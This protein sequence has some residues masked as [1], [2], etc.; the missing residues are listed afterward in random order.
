MPVPNIVTNLNLEPYYDTTQQELDKGYV[1]YLSIS[2]RVLQNRELNVS[3]GLIY[4]NVRK[5]TDL[6]VEDGSI[7]S[8]CNFV[9]NIINETCTLYSGEMY[10]NGVLVKIPEREWVYEE[11]PTEL[12]YVYVKITQEIVTENEDPSLFD[13]AENIENH[14]N[15]GGHRLKYNAIPEIMNETDFNAEALENKNFIPIIKLKNRNSYGPLK[16][17]PVFGKIYDYLAQRTYDSSGDFLA[18][19]LKV[20][21]ERNKDNSNLKFNVRVTKGRA[22]IRGY[23][24]SY[25]KDVYI[26]QDIAIDTRRSGGD[27][28]YAPEGET[29]HS[30]IN[31]Y[32]LNKLYIKSIEQI[33][34]TVETD[35]HADGWTMVYNSSTGIDSIP[36]QFNPITSIDL[37]Y[38]WSG[39]T[40]VPYIYNTDYA[41]DSGNNNIIWLSGGSHPAGTY[42]VDL[43][44]SKNLS[45]GVDYYITKDSNGTMVNFSTSGLKPKDGSVFFISYTWYLFRID[46]VYLTEDGYIN[47]KK[48]IPD[49]IENVLEPSIPLGTL[50][51][52][53]INVQP[54]IPPE[55]FGVKSF[56]IYR[57]PVTQ[58]QDMKRKIQDIEYNFAMSELENLAQNKHLEQ[59]DLT[60]LKNIF[61]DAVTDYKKADLNNPNYDATIDLFKSEIR[62]PMIIDQV[63][64][65]KVT[66]KN[67]ENENVLSK[68]F[69]LPRNSNVVTDFQPYATHEMDIAPFYYKGLSPTII[70]DPKKLVYIKDN[71]I[72]R[73]IWLDNRVVF[74]SS[75][76]KLWNTVETSENRLSGFAN[77]GLSVGLQES[78]GMGLWNSSN[79]SSRLIDTR[80]TV[81]TSTT[82]S[83]SSTIIGEEVVSTKKEEIDLVPQPFIKAGSVIKVT[84]Q[85]FP[86]NAE[87]GLL[88]D[89]QKLLSPEYVNLRYNSSILPPS[90]SNVLTDA[91]FDNEPVIRRDWVWEW[92]YNSSLSSFIITHPLYNNKG[93]SYRYNR[94]L[95]RWWYKY[96]DSVNWADLITSP[97]WLRWV[98]RS[99][100]I[101]HSAELLSTEN[102]ELLLDYNHYEPVTLA[103]YPN[104]FSNTK[105]TIITDSNGYFE[106]EIKIPENTPVG[107]HTIVAYNVLPENFDPDHKFTAVDEFSGESYIR[108][109]DDQIYKRK[110][111]KVIETVYVTTT[112]NIHRIFAIT[113]NDQ[114]DG[115]GERGGEGGREGG[116]GDPLAQSFIFKESQFL[117][118]I[119]LFFKYKS[120]NPNGKVFVNIREMVNGY[121]SDVILHQQI[122]KT[123]DVNI[124]GNYP[125]THIEFD[126]PVYIEGKKE[127]AFT[128]G[129]NIDGFH[130]LY[131]KMGNRDI[132]TGNAVIFQP[133]P[134][135]V[136]FVSSN[137]N[138]WSP[139]QDADIKYVLYRADFNIEN[140]KSVY[141]LNVNKNS[142]FCSNYFAMMNISIS[143]VILE[144]T[145]IKY[146]YAIN[147]SNPL[148]HT[149]WHSLSLE[150]MYKFV[151]T[152]EYIDDMNLTIKI[153]LISN[154]SK[155]T[156]VVN[157]SSFES[158]FAKYKTLGSYIQVPL[159][160]E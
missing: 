19:G 152:P 53:Y 68:L 51:L 159:N 50:P 25:D 109:W 158:F 90:T 136:M 60:S 125:A 117:T 73:I 62:N 149:L 4:G 11:V 139:I 123:S 86:A 92:Q 78:A 6:I 39:G 17:K 105:T 65:D 35:G 130:V 157:L 72:T 16:P 147:A 137:N 89:G 138:T 100:W 110:I 33:L 61:A 23:D 13:P 18:N 34:A 46:L 84:G 103:E 20:Y 106:A 145:D 45:L 14:G 26:V 56:N 55:Y 102:S 83:R 104:S 32:Y 129:C 9:N 22:Y 67:S 82:K 40:K 52:A 12:S 93:I 8:G 38:Q 79:S 37:V 77:F 101:A 112:T 128:I 15:R 88:L 146:E 153:S 30:G 74:S 99:P 98:V 81:T 48:G 148:T 21:A 70:C 66:V 49:E 95:N 64:I 156:P 76:V 150:E 155:L 36:A 54:E 29:Y 133:S 108:N 119:D 41:V 87:I 126:Y 3:Q 7:V 114:R 27:S 96:N 118:G 57:V 154:N 75:T 94:D 134:S 31:S 151:S 28:I 2:D 59:E 63:G 143:D 160:L 80:T 58:L 141:L 135:G 131:A 85:D 69:H 91:S 144:N 97:I 71:S 113:N 47:I 24:Y 44:Y 111:E 115:G 1:K 132:I 10:I 43:T 107:K 140:I 116:K 42:Y 122:V 142:N 124:G 121:P 5:V 127:Y 120:S